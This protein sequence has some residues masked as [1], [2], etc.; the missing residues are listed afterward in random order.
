MRGRRELDAA[1]KLVMPG[2]IDVHV[3]LSLP[4]PPGD[5][6]TWCDDFF[7]GTRAA[8]AGGITTVGN[9]TFP[10]PGQ[11]L[12]EAIERDA[13]AARRDA[14]VDVVLH[15]VLTDPATQPLADIPALAE[16]GHTTLKFFTSFGGFETQPEV[17]LEAMR[18]ARA[19]GAITM[20]HCE[21]AAIM[22]HATARLLA[23]GQG[24]IANY[25]RSRPIAAEVAATARAV[26]F[27]EQTGAPSYVVHLSCA[28]ALDEVRRGRARGL[29]L[30]VETRPLY[31]HLSE[32]RFA[33]PDGAKYVGQPPLRTPADRDAL[34]AGLAAGEV[35]A[36]CTD[37]APWRFADKVVPGMDVTTIRP[38]VA[39]LE[40]MLP[41]LWS[42]GVVAGRIS[43]Q[44]FVAATATNVAKLFG[45]FPQ[46]GIVAPGADADLIVWDPALTKSVRA[47][48]FVSNSDFSPYEGWPVTGWPLV[49]ISR[50]E[51]VFQ[52]GEVAERRG[53]GRLPRRGPTRPI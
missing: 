44:R 29:P 38:G 1:G 42:E 27:C 8:A 9:M 23:E 33:E 53:R 36:V 30:W 52:G 17:Y 14:I 35:D 25:P 20:I 11:T 32:E 2:G 31:L 16:A 22:A 26:A 24:E 21:D 6:P 34:W 28:A 43:R 15:P 50:G 45:L 37:H 5:G 12:R 51:V 18:L 13:A 7:S 39:D 46:K 48:E 4:S 3:H 47:A 41:M 19:A 40:T 10:W 49:T